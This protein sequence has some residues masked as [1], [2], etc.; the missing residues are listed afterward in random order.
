M[1]MNDMFMIF[2][3]EELNDSNVYFTY[4]FDIQKYA[5]IFEIGMLASDQ[6]G[7]Y[8]GCIQHMWQ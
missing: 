7:V 2:R 1:F 5:M 8:G 4:R 6:G 3:R